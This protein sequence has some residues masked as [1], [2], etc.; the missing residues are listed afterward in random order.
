M[1]FAFNENN[2]K[3]VELAI[4]K[5]PNGRQQSAVMEILYIAQEQNGWISPDVMVEIGRIL[6]IS[7]VKVKE[8]ATFYTMYCK[9]VAQLLVC[10]GVA[11]SF[12][13]P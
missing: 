5:Y 7:P 6:N 4:G 13:N 10:L 2:I 9:F 1:A 11:M 12:W 8:V 3:R